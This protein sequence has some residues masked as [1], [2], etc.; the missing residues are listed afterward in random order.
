MSV[1]DY[2]GRASA[3]AIPLVNNFQKILYSHF[4]PYLIQLLRIFFYV[5][6]NS[7]PYIYVCVICYAVGIHSPNDNVQRSTAIQLACFDP[8]RFWICH[9]YGFVRFIEWLFKCYSVCSGPKV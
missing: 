1:G 4:E 7:R 2:V 5:T 8:E 3:G 6:A 9:C